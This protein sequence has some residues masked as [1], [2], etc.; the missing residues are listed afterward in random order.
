MKKTTKSWWMYF[1]SIA[2]REHF[3]SLYLV[4]IMA[5][6]YITRIMETFLLLT[7]YACGDI[8]KM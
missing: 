4:I 6:E 7:D 5:L 1:T 2:T 3:R 8:A